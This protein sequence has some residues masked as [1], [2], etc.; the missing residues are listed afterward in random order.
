VSSGHLKGMSD[1]T[2]LRWLPTV[3]RLRKGNPHKNPMK[4]KNQTNPT[5]SSR[6]ARWLGAA[7]ILFMISPPSQGAIIYSQAF[8]AGSP[9]SIKATAVS[10]SSGT[11]GGTAGATWTANT[12]FQSN[13]T[14]SATT[15][16]MALLAFAPTVGEVYEL[17]MTVDNLTSGFLGIGFADNVSFTGGATQ[18]TNND[19]MITG[20]A[21]NY[22]MMFLNP[23]QLST[24][25]MAYTNYSSGST[26]LDST[27]FLPGTVNIAGPNT[28][29][30]VMDTT[31]A[32]WTTEYF[33][34]NTSVEFF[35]HAGALTNIDSVGITAGNATTATTFSDFKLQTIPEPGTALLGGLGVLGL[36]RR[37]RP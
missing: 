11:L 1:P 33:I 12:G 7:S 8:D 32:N 30:I 10:T 23:F 18:V 15:R 9:A 20:T 26:T 35:T 29:K 2:I 19:R 5:S 4:L 28:L 27:L 31:A 24:N 6:P 21:V 37:R 16:S 13:G 3:R 22:G 34:N 36:L 14:L 25:G 17:S